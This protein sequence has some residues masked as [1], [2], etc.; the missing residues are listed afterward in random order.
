[1][2]GYLVTWLCDHGYQSLSYSET[3]AV[4]IT[5]PKAVRS[6]HELMGVVRCL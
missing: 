2:P 1:M 3:H 4:V 6:L 5:S